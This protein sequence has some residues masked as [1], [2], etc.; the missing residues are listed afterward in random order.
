MQRVGSSRQELQRFGGFDG[1]DH[2]DGGIEHARRVA[3]RFNAGRA[4][5][6]FATVAVPAVMIRA[7][8]FEQARKAGRFARP[9]RHRDAVTPDGSRIN[10]R[11]A[12][13]DRRIVQK[14]ARLEI[15]RTVENDGKAGKKVGGVFRREVGHDAFD[16]G[17]GIDSAQAALG[18]DG[19]G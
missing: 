15:V 10:P 19:F 17:A 6:S 11:D 3:G 1:S 14:Q 7:A 16:F 13:R 8:A 4:G 9:N 2:A 18:G 12:Q 5:N